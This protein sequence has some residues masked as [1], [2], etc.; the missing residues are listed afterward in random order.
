MADRPLRIEMAVPSMD[1][2]GMETMVAELARALARRGHDVG[3]TCLEHEGE[4]APRLAADG[5]T[6]TVSPARGAVP[7]VL[8]GAT[9]TWFR[10]RRPDLV[11]IHSGVWLKAV[12]AAKSAGVPR[13]IYTCHGL[14]DSTPLSLRLMM[15]LAAHATEA[16]IAVSEPL[17]GFLTD[18]VR[19]PRAKV[20]VVANGIDTDRFC[21]GPRGDLRGRLM[22]ASDSVVVG[23]VARLVAGKNIPMLIEGF[24]RVA[25]AF[26]N[27]HLVIA[28]D[29]PDRPSL[30]KAVQ[31]T[32]LAA[33][34]HLLGAVADTAV[35][36]RD[37][38]VFVLP[39]LAEGTSI[40]ILEA[41]AT[42]ISII[43]TSVG[44]NPALLA[45]GTA[46]RLVPSGHPAALADA[47]T[48][49]VGDPDLRARYGLRARARAVA[50]YSQAAMVDHY[51][52]HYTGRRA[53]AASGAA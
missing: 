28:G 52:R 32:G 38:D 23:V 27:A 6:V 17:A 49:L 34:I 16:C 31:E 15:R 30:E 4:L 9:G 47:L 51:L 53:A 7:L 5:I 33:R 19:V 26:P 40:S 21:P 48:A 20:H 41:M 2:G 37:L 1:V 42:G 22:I 46:G 8:A 29:G 18:E 39:S 25:A 35:L 13:M 44:G 24:H 36:Y 45:A 43:A 3:I 50:D 11:H 14:L 12:T 10:A